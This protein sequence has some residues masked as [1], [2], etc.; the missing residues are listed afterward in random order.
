MK[1]KTIKPAGKLLR[2]TID[3]VQDKE[4]KKLIHKALDIY[5]EEMI[6]IIK[7]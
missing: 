6:N 3:L 7:K 5:L 4:L 2:E 1:N